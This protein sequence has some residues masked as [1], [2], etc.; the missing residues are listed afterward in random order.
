MRSVR[1]SERAIHDLLDIGDFIAADDRAAAHRWVLRIRARARL[2][3][4]APYSG[5]QVPEL[6]RDDVRE[7][8]LRSYRIVYR[9][10]AR[11]VVVVTVFEGRRLF[12]VVDADAP[13]T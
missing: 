12:P 1:W 4:A 13:A 2:A 6:G 5:R 10:M 3:A 7:T 9:V 8:F 11:A